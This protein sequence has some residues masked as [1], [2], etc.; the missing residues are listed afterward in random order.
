MI[1]MYSSPQLKGATF[2]S[3][4]SRTDAKS[5]T[6]LISAW[7]SRILFNAELVQDPNSPTSI[8]PDTRAT[9]RGGDCLPVRDYSPSETIRMNIPHLSMISRL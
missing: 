3:D 7:C 6:L 5:G 1:V 2:E 4:T 9:L 8:K